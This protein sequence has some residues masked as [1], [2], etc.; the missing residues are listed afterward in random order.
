M[1][2]NTCLRCV[3]AALVLSGGVFHSVH[4][5]HSFVFEFDPDQQGS[6]IGEVNEVRFVNPHVVYRMQAELPDG[7]TEAWRLQTHNVGVMQRLGWSAATIQVGDRIEVFGS[8]GRS[9]I[10]K[11]SIDSVILADGSRRDP[12]GG[13]VADAYTTGEVNAD[14]NKFYGVTTNTY[15]ADITG[16]WS[17]R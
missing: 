4:A 6:L 9:G 8:L 12:K 3:A 10:R 1:K 5:H 14:P 7:T 17:N 15:P 11:L 16:A 13:E 2:A